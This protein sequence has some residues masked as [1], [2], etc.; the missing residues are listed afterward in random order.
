LNSAVNACFGIFIVSISN[1]T[2]IIRY[3]W[4]TIFRGKLNFDIS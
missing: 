3:P 2:S 4:K 1:V